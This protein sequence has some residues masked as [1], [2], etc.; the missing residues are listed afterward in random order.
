ME[1]NMAIKSATTKE[2]LQ[3]VTNSQT[4]ESKYGHTVSN[5]KG[6]LTDSYQ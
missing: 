3:I 2:Y 5:Y 1:A 6:I 4:D